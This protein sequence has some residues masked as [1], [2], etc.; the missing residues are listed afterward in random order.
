MGFGDRTRDEELPFL[1]KYQV[2]FKSK[3]KISQR[4]KELERW[5]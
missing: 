3:L 5:E 4:K 1:E 2:K